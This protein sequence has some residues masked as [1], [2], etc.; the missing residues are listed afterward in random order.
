MKFIKNFGLKKIIKKSLAKYQ[1]GVMPDAVTTV[2]V[3]TDE[4]YF[5]YRTAIVKELIKHG[6]AEKNIEVLSFRDHISSK[7]VIKDCYTL[8]D[9]SLN[10]TFKKEEV[11]A[12]V[13]KRFDMLISYYE[14]EKLPLVAVTLKSKAKFKVGFSTVDS[15]LNDFT[16][17][18]AAQKHEVFISELFKY[19]KILN[20]I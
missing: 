16:I 7:E 19:L 18:I 5:K 14:D 12:F 1:A 11:T 10:G 2:G 20:K 13:H 3:L 15:R 17:T 9:I 6:I 8:A 4:H